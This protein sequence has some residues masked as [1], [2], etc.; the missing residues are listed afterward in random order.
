MKTTEERVRELEGRVRELEKALYD[1][2]F[3]KVVHGHTTTIITSALRLKVPGIK[4]LV[5]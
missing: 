2:C 4:E 3:E 5:G 1:A